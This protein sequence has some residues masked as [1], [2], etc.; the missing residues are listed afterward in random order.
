MYEWNLQQKKDVENYIFME[1]SFFL[2]E[3]EKADVIF[4]PGCPRPDLA[5]EA[6]G[7]YRKGAA[8]LI[9]PSG[10]YTKVQGSFLGVNSGGER[11]GKDFSCEADFLHA[12]LVA[13]G[14][15][16]EAIRKEREA[17]YTLENAE[18]TRELME[19]EKIKVKKA[20]LCCKSYHA[21]RAYLY[22]SMVFP[23]LEIRIHPVCVDGISRENWSDTEKGRQT[24]FGELKRMG[25]QLIMMEDRIR[26]GK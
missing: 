9:I 8:P 18:K 5:V 12:V 24:V 2:G 22:Y 23:E 3:N 25:E 20:I 6:A 19:R 17:T 10:A 26:W 1:S 13:H 16:E 21:R 14:V 7:L 11:Y 15:P 4:V